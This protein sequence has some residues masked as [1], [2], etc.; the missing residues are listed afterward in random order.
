MG[1]K[2]GLIKQSYALMFDNIIIINPQIRS[3]LG[4]EARTFFCACPFDDTMFVDSKFLIPGKFLKFRAELSD[5]FVIIRAW[6]F[7]YP[8]L[9]LMARIVHILPM[10]MTLNP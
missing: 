4:K 3:D 2:Y 6:E 10:F 7:Y 8:L 1:L 5:I 9:F